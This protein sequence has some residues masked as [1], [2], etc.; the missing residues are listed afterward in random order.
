MLKYEMLIKLFVLICELIFC[1][2]GDTIRA[3]VLMLLC[4]QLALDCRRTI[5]HQ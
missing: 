1:V 4:L 5:Q 3:E 2:S